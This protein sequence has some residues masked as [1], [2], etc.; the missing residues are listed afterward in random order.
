MKE[1]VLRSEN[2]E[3]SL[4][5]EILETDLSDPVN[6]ALYVSVKSGGYS[7]SAALG[8]NS[9]AFAAFCA[10]VKKLYDVQNGAAVI[11]E[12]GENGRYIS[13]SGEGT[14][15]IKL[16]GYL[17]D[18]SRENELYFGGAADRDDLRRFA[19]ELYAKYENYK[20]S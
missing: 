6:A 8:I 9:K 5:F 14:G 15:Q 1:Y 17:C 19:L 18:E 16:R 10:D 2:F 20:L 7:A 4:G 13:L 3:L 11:R 12:K